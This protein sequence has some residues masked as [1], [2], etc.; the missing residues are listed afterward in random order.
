MGRQQRKIRAE[1]RKN[2]T[3]RTR[4]T[5]WTQQFH[6]ADISEDMAR[7]ERVSGKG[8]LARRRTVTG[9]M[10]ESDDGSAF[11]VVLD[12]D[13][14]GCL[15]GRVLCVRG[16]VNTVQTDDGAVCAMCHAAIAQDAQHR[17]AA[18]RR[19]RRPR[20][21]SALARLAGEGIIQRVEPRRGCVSRVSGGRQQ[22]LVANIDQALVVVSAAQPR[23]KPNLIDRFLISA[24]KGR[25]RPVLC[26]NKI[27][28]VEPESLVPL[29]GLY[30]QMGYAVLR[31]AWR[32]GLDSIA[33]GGPSRDIRAWSSAKAAW[34]NRRCLNALDPSLALAVATVSPRTRRAATR[35]PPP[36]SCRCASAAAS[37]IRPASAA[38]S[39]GT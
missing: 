13:A 39:F 5:D 30:S 19:G 29:V 14:A 11:G 23:L 34:E 12:V 1:F 15:P 21:L 24:E 32:P 20:A 7:T 4:R 31:P 6:Q 22:V 38:S 8:D 3:T 10:Q 35:R 9:Q 36:G 16:L 18:A 25:I 27:D 17:S 2:R 33:C 26:I 37:S 28:L